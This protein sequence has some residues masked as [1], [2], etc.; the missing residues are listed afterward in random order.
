[1]YSSTEICKIVPSPALTNI[2]KRLAELYLPEA[3][4][5]LTDVI[6]T[7]AIPL[8]YPND[9]LY[10][11]K[12]GVN[13]FY[14]TAHNTINHDRRIPGGIMLLVNGPGHFAQSLVMHGHQESMEKAI[15]FVYNFTIRSIGNGV[16]DRK[17]G[18]TCTLHNK[19][20]DSTD[21]LENL[22]PANK[23]LPNYV[24]E[25]FDSEKFSGNYHND[26]LI[27]QFITE[28][29]ASQDMKYKWSNIFYDY[30]SDD[31]LPYYHPSFGWWMEMPVPDE[32]IFFN[33]W[34]PERPI[35]GD[36]I[37]APYWSKMLKL[38]PYLSA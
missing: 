34:I 32:A 5:I 2:G 23:K 17:Q 13:M 12:G 3:R 27:P 24:P 10:L 25:S 15:Q 18:G 4:P 19:T 26:I 29:I 8:R 20:S 7:E 11:H 6:Y 28:N 35:D 1:M 22:V 14:P 9:L 36:W 31:P 21:N 33:P 16:I 30:F 38:H 37:S